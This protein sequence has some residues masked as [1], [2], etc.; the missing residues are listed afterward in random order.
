MRMKYVVVV[1]LLCVVLILP[2][3]SPIID[4]ELLDT[5]ESSQYP[6]TSVSFTTSQDTQTG[7]MNPITVEQRGYYSTGNIAARTDTGV[8]TSSN[9]LIDTPNNWIGDLAELNTWNLTSLYAINGTFDAGIPGPN[10]NPNMTVPTQYY[11]YGWN[12]TSVTT[13]TG[14]TQVAAYDSSGSKFVTVENQGLKKGPSGNQY[15]HYA[16]TSVD[17]YQM[18]DNSPYTNEFR[19]KF[20]FLYFRGP[21]GTATPGNASLI[22]KANDT[23][24]WDTQLPFVPQRGTWY[25][26]DQPINTTGLGAMFN[27]S[28]GLI[29]DDTMTLNSDVSYDG[30]TLNGI[31]NTVYITAYIDDLSFTGR[32]QPTP[33]QVDLKFNVN[34]QNATVGGSANDG[35]ASYVNSSYWETNSIPY[36]ILS[37]SSVTLNYTARILTHLFKN[38]N[39]GP[40]P[41]TDG[42]SYTIG[43]G[44]SARISTYTY[45]GSL[46]TYEEFQLIF[47][48]PIDWVNISVYDPFLDDI[49]SQSTILPGNTTIPHTS[50][51]AFGYWNIEFDSINYVRNITTQIYDSDLVSWTNNSVFRPSNS[52]RA[53]IELGVTGQPSPTISSID[54][55]WILPNSTIWATESSASGIDGVVNSS[56]Q[57]LDTSLAGLWSIAAF[58]SNGSEIGYDSRTFIV[59]H[60]S[61]L[62]PI[63]PTIETE[64]GQIITGLVRFQDVDNG[65]YLMEGATIKANWSGD[66]L[67]FIP[68]PTRKW[69][70]V[71]LDTTGFTPGIYAVRV[72][73][74]LE[75][76][77]DSV[78]FISIEVIGT[79]NTLEIRESSIE[80]SLLETYTTYLNYT[81][82]SGIGIEGADISVSLI[83]PAGGISSANVVDLGEGN[84]SIDLTALN[85]G[86][87]SITI[88]A[89]KNHYE[90]AHDSLIILIGTFDATITSENGTAD[91]ITFGYSYQ[92]VLRYTNATGYGLS[93]ATVSISSISPS[94]GLLN[95]SIIDEGNGYYSV[96]LIATETGAYTILFEAEILNHERVLYSFTLSSTTVPTILTVKSADEIFPIDENSTI[97]LEF[98]NETGGGIEGAFLSIIS[99]PEGLTYSSF[100]ELGSGVYQLVL[101]PLQVGD[102]QIRFKATA[103]NHIDATTSISVSVELI[104]T[105]LTMLN[106]DE[107]LETEFGDNIEIHLQLYRTDTLVNISG[108]NISLVSIGGQLPDYNISETDDYYIIILYA[109]TVESYEFTILAEKLHCRDTSLDIQYTVNPIATEVTDIILSTLYV[110]RQYSYIVEFKTTEGGFGILGAEIH[111][112]GRGSDWITNES[113]G[114]GSYNLTISPADYGTFEIELD[115]MKNG[116]LT[117]TLVLSFTANAIPMDMDL[118]TSPWHEITGFTVNLTLTASDFGHIG[119]P[120]SGAIIQCILRIDGI[121]V[122]D[123]TLDEI[124][125][126][127]YRKS[128]LPIWQSSDSVSLHIT[129]NKEF[130]LEITDVI[131][132][133]QVPYQRST[134]EVFVDFI[135]VPLFASLGA[136]FGIAFSVR[137]YGIRKDRIRKE[138]M[139]I[140]M[141]FDDVNNLLGILVLHKRSGL[142]I[143]SKVLKGGFEEGMLSAFITAITHFRSEFDSN[144]KD[145]E[146]EWRITPIS[147]IIR[148]VPTHNLICA[149]VTL[150]TPSMLQEANML[151]FSRSIGMAL[152]ADM[153][154]APTQTVD[155]ETKLWIESAFDEQ[156]DGHL[157]KRYSY[158]PKKQ[159]PRGFKMISE[160]KATAGLGDDFLLA[161][162]SRGFISCGFDEGA[163]YKMILD[164]IE[165][166]IL[167]TRE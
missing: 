125:P 75:Y 5:Q 136:L 137:Y 54:L 86:T 126:G 140:K 133:V 105:Q 110:G 122:L 29:I 15:E 156:L 167:S 83:E 62:T 36:A 40:S 70:E 50:I 79:D 111:P 49:T 20:R 76:F 106:Q 159:A 28:I 34:G 51:D 69:W 60:R 4:S 123:W 38:S 26:V 107:S 27:I 163:A 153:E 85:S 80:L 131:P 74:S 58:W 2:T 59:I 71:D 10:I 52:S 160:A 67:S 143:Y 104:Q 96:L 100:T 64:A 158:L 42:V 144:G 155:Y 98:T 65:Y 9:L 134:L 127:L 11:P 18:V 47:H 30:V 154:I 120:V 128:I 101:T 39:P 124:T 77:E 81:D 117:S 93:G 108:A 14:Q 33:A 89:T 145:E 135:M 31:E 90:I 162:L 114:D 17:W 55:S 147:D 19:L 41:L 166:G 22:V 12:A 87:Y 97:L 57:I 164:A 68:N 102:Y 16:G 53:V 99:P 88:Q 45:L 115:F 103:A 63:D 129:V 13:N 91:S 150:T 84:Y 24:I 21:L 23:I 149:F 44:E 73:A 121:D 56:E 8:G 157:L 116:Y 138:L 94:S 132:I 25:Q 119:E 139:D 78:C 109:D 82:S 46:G 61:S 1:V 112:S 3:S 32:N 151:I 152:D 165:V 6:E 130:Y 66:A 146:F 35:Y 43:I 142:P 72:N 118:F 92:F 161:E 37:N 48:Y 113:L 95:G 7:T 148:A 141:R